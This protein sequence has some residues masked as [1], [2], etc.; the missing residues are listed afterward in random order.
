[1]HVLGTPPAFI[2]SQDQTL[3]KNLFLHL[4]VFR[5]LLY[6]FFLE[7]TV[8]SSYHSSIVK[9]PHS[10]DPETLVQCSCDDAHC[11]SDKETAGDYR[12]VGDCIENW[13]LPYC[14]LYL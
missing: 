6:G 14:P 11:L 13:P 10:R 3:R 5:F 12:R 7:Q 9:V 1:L 4:T 8:L 2:L